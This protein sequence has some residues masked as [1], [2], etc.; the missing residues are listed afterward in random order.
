MS[1]YV[2]AALITIYSQQLHLNSIY[3]Y[4][5][6]SKWYKLFSNSS[7]S[8]YKKYENQNLHKYLY[9]REGAGGRGGCWPQKRRLL[10]G[11]IKL[12]ETWGDKG[13]YPLRNSE[14]RG[15]VVYGCSLRSYN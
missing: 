14:N 6:V 4:T 8:K 10:K 7:L 12:E 11:V 2:P 9:E 13:R 3:I 1:S 5:Y 15:D